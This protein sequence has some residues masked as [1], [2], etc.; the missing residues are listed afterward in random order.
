[1]K[2]RIRKINGLWYC[3]LKPHTQEEALNYCIGLGYTAAGAYID[4]HNLSKFAGYQVVY[5]Y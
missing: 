2:P 5:T 1:M 4:W 3:F